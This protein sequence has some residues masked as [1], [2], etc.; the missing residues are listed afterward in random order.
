MDHSICLNSLSL[1]AR[2]AGKAYDM[3][4]DACHGMLELGEAGEDRFFLYYDDNQN[5]RLLDCVLAG[6]YTYNSF[7]KALEERNEFDL[8]M[9]LLEIEDKSP[10]LDW[11]LKER[12]DIF[13]ELC[14]YNF[15]LPE[16]GSNECMDTLGMAWL[17]DACLLSLPTKNIWD[18]SQVSIA[19]FAEG[20]HQPDIYILNN[21][22]RYE[23][24][25]ELRFERERLSEQT[26]D[27]ICAQ[28]RFTDIFMKWY[29][30]LDND[31]RHRVQ[32]KLRVASER[33]FQGGEPLFKTLSDADGMREIRFSAFP[34]GAMRVLFGSLPDH[35]QAI[36]VGFIKKSDSEGY[37][38]NIQRAKSL[39][40][41]LRTTGIRN[42]T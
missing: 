3:L 2:N 20:N 39:W 42:T 30:D 35:N 7:L 14:S 27:Q 38:T 34:G 23:H 4:L 40:E 24:G 12:E 36:L 15:Y 41:Q 8:L 25:R 6:N 32:S 10:A 31:N 21:I 17:L 18:A 22:A 11:I 1:P 28:C 26:L 5:N 9:F 19:R 16:S 29:D 37:K 13:D 33:G